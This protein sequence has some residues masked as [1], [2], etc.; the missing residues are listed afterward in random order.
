VSLSGA[1]NPT[2]SF[3][4][5]PDLAGGD[6][7]QVSL[8]G[9]GLSASRTFAA[10]G[11]AEW[12]HAWLPLNLPDTVSGPLSVS[13]DLSGGQVSLDEVSLGDGPQI[14]FLPFILRSSVP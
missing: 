14:I 6:T 3:W 10:G 5:R 11:A 2:L 9:S 1:Y 12:G 8:E 13:F 4:Y 7:L